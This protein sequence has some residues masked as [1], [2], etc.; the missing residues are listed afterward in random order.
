M[1]MVWVGFVDIGSD[2]DA[3][4]TCSLG[5]ACAGVGL[6]KLSFVAITVHGLGA[7]FRAARIEDSGEGAQ[8][9]EVELYDRGIIPLLFLLSHNLLTSTSSALIDL[10]EYDLVRFSHNL[11]SL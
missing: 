6:D 7:K 10:V 2:Q 8:V 4:G 1:Y 5:V 11:P 3:Q 9:P